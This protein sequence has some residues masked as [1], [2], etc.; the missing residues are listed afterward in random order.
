MRFILRTRLVASAVAGA[1]AIALLSACGGGDN[2]EAEIVR[3]S[4]AG[5]L[6][7]QRADSARRAGQSDN[8]F[9]FVRYN[10]DVSG[11]L[12]RACLAFSA[13]L[14]P[15]RDYSGYLDVSPSS[16]MRPPFMNSALRPR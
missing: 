7:E 6:M 9:E 14:D 10:I 16:Q 15:N 13:S 8:A 4:P 5:P 11:D 12:P 2:G 3:G 1:C